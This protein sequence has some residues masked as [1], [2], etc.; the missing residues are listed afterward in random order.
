MDRIFA[1]GLLNG[2]DAPGP[3]YLRLQ[4]LIREAIRDGRLELDQALPPEREMA[5]AFKVSR[6]T[7]RKAIQGLATEG[8][9][10]QRHGSGTYV[11]R[12]QERRQHALSR[13]NSFTEDMQIRGMTPASHWLER[14]LG[15]ATPEEAM[16]LALSPGERVCR[17]FRLRLADA[18]PM[19]VERAVVPHRFLPD[20]QAVDASL[21]EALDRVGH[22]PVRALQRMSAEALV[23]EDAD[24]LGVPPGTAVLAAER[25]AFLRSGE[26][27]EFTRSHYRGDTYDFVAELILSEGPAT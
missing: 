1:A 24:L 15:R 19:A 18:R 20:P 7:V 9:V 27:V 25:L 4:A 6:V 16:Q 23:G 14:S 8:V 10:R 3:L 12:P 21:Y 5:A 22:R 11:A 17:L 2:E 13:L 26:M